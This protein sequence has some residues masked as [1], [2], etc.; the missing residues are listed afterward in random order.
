MKHLKLLGTTEEERILKAIF[1]GLSILRSKQGLI[2]I[3]EEIKKR[4]KRQI[5][6]KVSRALYRCLTQAQNNLKSMGEG[7]MG[8]LHWQIR[9]QPDPNV[10]YEEYEDNIPDFSW[11]ILDSLTTFEEEEPDR[12]K[13]H[14]P[15]NFYFHIECKRLGS[16]TSS[17][18]K[19]NPNYVHHGIVRFISEGHRYG[20]HTQSGAM[21]GYLEDMT[22][23]EILQEVNT[24]IEQVMQTPSPETKVS[25]LLPLQSGWQDKATS[26]LTHQLERSFP[27][28]PFTLWHFWLDLRDCYARTQPKATISAQ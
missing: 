26:R 14:L 2:W 23:K 8:T 7:L 21:I 28:S 13:S 25:P 1:D 3:D 18:W 4:D 10:S 6:D 27:K 9:I 16:P 19:L 20:Q 12:E 24:A 15:L 5:E 17:S 22:C 11:Q